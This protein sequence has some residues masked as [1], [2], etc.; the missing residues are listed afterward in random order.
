MFVN[1]LVSMVR[2]LDIKQFSKLPLDFPWL[3]HQHFAMLAMRKSK[4]VWRKIEVELKSVWVGF[5]Q[6]HLS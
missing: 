4:L 2:S 3:L 5:L 6:S 1:F